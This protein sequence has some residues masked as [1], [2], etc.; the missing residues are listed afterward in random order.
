MKSRSLARILLPVPLLFL[1]CAGALSAQADP[2][3]FQELRW[4]SIGPYRGGRVTAVAGVASAPRVYYMGATGG[5]VWKT[6][7]AGIRWTPISDR[8]FKTGSVGA[9]AVAES[10]PNVIYVGMG[11][12]CLRANLSHGDGVYKSIDGGKT[13]S[14]VGLDETS[15]IGS[16][17]IDPRDPGIVYVAAVGHPYGPNEERGVFRSVDGG[18]TW[19]KVLYVNDKTGAVDLAMDRRHPLTIY[20]AAWQVLRTPWKIEPDGPGSGIYKTTDGGDHWTKLTDGLPATD[21]GKIGLAIS[22]VNSDRVWATIGGDKGGI[23]RSDDGGRNWQLL[24]GDFSMTS[25]QYYYGHIFADSQKADTVYT[26]TNKSF[27]VST[28][29]GT[30]WRRMP[31]TTHGDYHGFWMDPHDDTRWIC[32]NDGGA[33]VTFDGGQTYSSEMNQPTAQ[34]YTVTTDNAFP[35]RVYGAQQDNTTV[36]IASQTAGPGIDATDWYEVGGG[37]SGYVVPD[38]ANP[39]IVYAG[40]YWGTLT[41]Y[42]RRNGTV[43][44]IAVWPD[45]PG[46]RSAAEMKYRFQW[47]FPI[48]ISPADP[49]TIYAGANVLFRSTDQGQSWQAISPDLTRNDKQRESG[50]HLEDI[51]C[52]IF[53]IAPSPVDKNVIWTGS[54]DGLVHLTRDGGRTWTDVTPPDVAPWTR[55]NIIEA[56]P[57]DP[58][59]AYVAANRYQVDDF[60][61][62]LYRTHDFGKTWTL[63]TTG[64]PTNTFVRTVREDRVRKGLLFAGTE[65]GVY[66]S[67]D[68]GLQW[69]SLQLN[70]PVVPITDLTVKDNDLIAATQGRSFWILDDITP[71]EQFPSQASSGPAYLF[72]PRPA[73]RMQ[74]ARFFGPSAGA[75]Q[76]PPYGVIVDYSLEDAA[77][78]P[79][80]LAFLDAAGNVIQTFSSAEKPASRFGGDAVTAKQGLNRFVW[81]MRYPDARGIAGGTYLSGGNL[82]GPEAAPGR[83]TV[84]LTA[85]GQTYTQPFEIRKD[86]R[87]GTTQAGYERQLAMLL[88]VRDKLSTANDTINAIRGIEKQ[89]EDST[90]RVSGDSAFQS[91]ASHLIDKL[92]GVL[93]ELYQP[94]YTG[95][96]DQMLVYPLK[97][98]NRI[99]ALEGYVQGEFAPTAQDEQVFAALTSELDAVLA[100]WGRIQAAD[101][102]GFN[103]QL[104]GHGLPEIAPYLPARQVSGGE[105]SRR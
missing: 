30:T 50:G 19:Q 11:E 27:L 1:A 95:F 25:R 20:A 53:T 16:I 79:V 63:L 72:A 23:F 3:M 89:V 61:P 83:Y 41:R 38:P 67:F 42:D 96:D 48:A 43:R 102:P 85:G 65:T 22:P 66:V 64:I 36:A 70:L 81:D 104:R 17:A 5:G 15:Q 97:L 35:Y 44:S 75:G 4:R 7:D 29:G 39:D 90:T 60:R 14:H 47:T 78:Q 82:R 45:Y 62:Y 10:D 58:A 24:N 105:R 6:V 54:D 84:K 52:T 91:A 77:T 69:Q 76:N 9:I 93:G 59:T 32:G 100:E 71:L 94:H 103:G 40:A 68:D 18:Q 101:I 73:Y 21:M 46:G 51:Y 2:H 33:A 37:E 8:T 55:I 74:H 57:F 13:W 31:N 56:S 88:A 92:N 34:F 86:P 87:V 49:G 99:A 80:T 98:N 26:F 12:A 28:D